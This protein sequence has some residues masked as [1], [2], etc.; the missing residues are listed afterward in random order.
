MAGSVYAGAPLP[1]TATAAVKALLLPLYLPCFFD[2]M[3]MG[4]IGPTLPLFALSLGASE[5]VTGIV[6]ST[7][8]LGRLSFSVPGGQLVGRI[9][10]KRA[11]Q[12]GLM[13]RSPPA[14]LPPPPS[15][16]ACAQV[17]TCSSVLLA[18]AP[19]VPLVMLARLLAGG[20][21]Q[22]TGVGRQAFCAAAVAT[23]H[24]GRVVGLLGGVSRIGGIAGPLIGGL[25]AQLYGFRAAF[26][27]QAALNALG[28]LLVQLAMPSPEGGGGG[29]G[30]GRG[31]A[32]KKT[33]AGCC[34]IIGEF[35][36]S[37]LVSQKRRACMHVFQTREEASK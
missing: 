16:A 1:P 26:M 25:T 36:H 12:L 21:Q 33:G 20:G 14:P 35:W 18:L 5:G 30:G 3:A 6:V 24:R 32:K 4:I 11:I 23:H 37:L 8:A 28:V 15:P 17:Y 27:L 9:G 34:D 29:G 19:S 22:A 13:V 2:S 10:E 7:V 31:S